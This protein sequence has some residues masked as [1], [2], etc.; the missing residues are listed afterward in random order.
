MIFEIATRSIEEGDVAYLAQIPGELMTEAEGELV[1]Y[2]IR[3]TRK[4]GKPPSLKKLGKEFDWFY[5]WSFTPTK[6]N[7]D[8]PLLSESYDEFVTRKLLT[9]SDGLLAEIRQ[10]IRDDGKVDL[11]KLNQ[12]EKLHAL[13]EGVDSYTSF[14]RSKYFRGNKVDIPFT[15]LNRMIGGISEGDYC[16][17]IGRLGTGKSTISQFFAKHF[18]EQGKRILFISAEMLAVDV[19]AKIDGMVGKFNPRILRGG[20]SLEAREEIDKVESIIK[21]S[22]SGGE[23]VVPRQRLITPAAIGAMAKQLNVDMIFVD[24]VYLLHPSNARITSKWEK[25]LTV[26]NELK[27]IALDLEIPL[28]GTSQIKRGA[29]GDDGYD[30][31]DISYSDG[32]GQDADFILAIHQNSVVESQV[33]VQLIKNRYGPNGVTGVVI[34]Y[35]TM[36]IAE[37][38]KVKG[39]VSKP[40]KA[41]EW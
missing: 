39:A 18:Y 16:L 8:P 28:F 4:H 25:V 30:P 23:I 9:K 11:A 33:E 12:I 15:T 19:F 6:Y 32:L 40:V 22:E 10:S 20:D 2:V 14:N 13:T 24:G 38:H 36:T 26:S 35:D 3:Y 31:E 34:D 29:N 27:Q 37:E 41:S 7:P 5:P 1:D 17:V 21:K